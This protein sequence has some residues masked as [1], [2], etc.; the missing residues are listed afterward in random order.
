MTRRHGRLNF[1]LVLLVLLVVAVAPPALPALPAVGPPLPIGPEI[2]VNGS[3][4]GVQCN[5]QVA[6]FPD[7]GFVV[8]WT[9]AP[10]G[11]DPSACLYGLAN[12]LHARRFAAD[13]SPASREIR[14]VRPF[15]PQLAGSVAALADGSFLVAY[16]QAN[17]RGRR[18]VMAAR[19]GPDGAAILP[20]F[21]VHAASSLSRFGGRVAVEPE[22]GG[23]AVA[24]S[25]LAFDGPD[26]PYGHQ[27]AYA[28]RFDATGRPLG[29]EIR[30]AQGYSQAGGQDEMSSA[31]ALAA[32]G[33]FWVATGD[34]GDD[35][36]VSASRVD[37]TGRVVRQLQASQRPPQ[38]DAALSMAADGSLVL[39]WTHGFCGFTGPGGGPVASWAERLTADGT[40]LDKDPIQL[41]RRGGC[42]VQPQIAAFP[43]GSFVALWTDRTG[44]DG[45]G[46]GVFGRAFGPDGAPQT[47]DFRVNVTTDGDQELSA[48]AANANGDVVAVWTQ[49]ANPAKIVAR[50]LGQPGG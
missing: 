27:D 37:A 31:V 2:R 29:P 48:I 13:G 43:G 38:A 49:S 6:V 20:P 33:S 14:L 11:T 24:W 1:F 4:A 40:P 18:I 34:L 8:V 28:R 26:D 3:D 44:R 50:R 47:R 22:G 42:E 45:S 35:L 39:A 15:G 9:V 16:E 23:F 46:A 32:D 7:G 12:T 10:G 21:R 25:A 5:P 41:N 30:V 17:A 19:F 36:T